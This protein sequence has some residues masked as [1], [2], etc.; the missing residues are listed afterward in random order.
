M[1]AGRLHKEQKDL[2]NAG[3]AAQRLYIGSSQTWVNAKKVNDAHYNTL[4]ELGFE[5]HILYSPCHEYRF[6][7]KRTSMD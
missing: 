2:I 5:D 1:V 3:L 6:N 7:G 4:K